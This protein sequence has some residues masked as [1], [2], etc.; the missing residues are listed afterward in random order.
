MA[1]QSQWFSIYYNVKPELVR[2]RSTQFTVSFSGLS[3]QRRSRLIKQTEQ[4]LWFKAGSREGL[5]ADPVPDGPLGS[6]CRC[7]VLIVC[8]HGPVYLAESVRACAFRGP[9]ECC[10][11]VAGSVWVDAGGCVCEV[12][13][14]WRCVDVTRV[15]RGVGR[16]ELMEYW[17]WVRQRGGGA[18]HG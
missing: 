2:R 18:S 15:C 11:C 6:V 9:C 13:A 1:I 16:T 7:V 3:F 14:T 10:H 17:R 8:V 12:E 5:W 4:V